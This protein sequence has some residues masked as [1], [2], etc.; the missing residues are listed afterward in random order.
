MSLIVL[1]GQLVR[2]A[3]FYY[4]LSQL[5]A[6]GIGLVTAIEQLE[7]NPPSFSYRKPLRLLV[8]Q[9][10]SGATFS[11]ALRATSGW[12][13][14]FDIAL[15]EAGERSG[16]IDNCLKTLADYYQARAKLLKQVM[17]Q[18]M[19]PAFLVHFAALV[20]CVVVPWA[21]SGFNANLGTLFFRAACVLAPIYV[22]VALG[23]YAFQSKHG[24][25][26]RA[27]IESV[28][29]F[30]PILGKARHAM[31]LSRLALALE[32]LISAGVNII[33]AWF[34]AADATASPAIRRTVSSWREEFALG[35][36]PATLV[37]N[38][39]KFPSLFVN[40]YTTGEVSGKL[41]ESLHR[42]RDYYADEGRRKFEALAEWIPR[43][44]YLAVAIAIAWQI[45]KFYTGYFNQVSAI[46]NGF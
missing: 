36:T 12:L 26:W 5:T 16:R 21:G 30:V 33:E 35:H 2:R 27:H 4:Q 7:K 6:A 34:L 9:I 43:G 29:H 25:R 37:A 42:L 45:I 10:H 22:L 32:A 17:S 20:F 24:E 18:M 19:Y 28:L 11:D 44:I 13:P 40:F 8:E 31:V 14:Q 46:T 23:I 3:G 1:P 39:G 15:I 41:D 38:S